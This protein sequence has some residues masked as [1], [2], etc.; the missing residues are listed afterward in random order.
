MRQRK[1]QMIEFFLKIV[2]IA[3]LIVG[4]W[5]IPALAETMYVKSAK[6]KMT[7][8]P[9]ARS[10]SLGYLSAGQAVKVIA[11]EGR[12]IKVSVGGKKG[13]I[14]KFKLTSK[15]P[16]GGGGGGGLDLL[17]GNQKMAAAESSSGSSIRGLSPISENYARGH[18]IS[19]A[20]ISAVKKMESL[21]F[22]SSQID[23][24]QEQG[25]I[26]PYAK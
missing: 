12:F 7:A 3:A 1:F 4:L 20:D 9:S 24:F 16:S 14:F 2:T 21:S 10:K 23:A 22:S 25:G 18:G 8:E 6:T 19:A 17:S 5:V 15:A 26:G 11:K 13:Y